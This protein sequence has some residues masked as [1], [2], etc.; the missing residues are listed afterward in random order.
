MSFPPRAE[1]L[2][3]QCLKMT[4][5]ESEMSIC[6]VV[7][8]RY[9][10]FHHYHTKQQA[11]AIKHYTQVGVSACVLLIP[12]IFYTTQAKSCQLKLLI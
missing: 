11:E 9:A 2:F 8:Q 4:K 3:Q 1:Q 10:D 6:Q 5:S 12:E 7:H